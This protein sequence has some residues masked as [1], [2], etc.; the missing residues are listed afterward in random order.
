M[1][2][3]RAALQ[4]DYTGLRVRLE[5]LNDPES[6]FELGEDAR[7]AALASLADEYL[8]PL[9]DSYERLERVC[10]PRVVSNQEKKPQ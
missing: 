5:Q 1:S 6:R 10:Y 9:L 4:P 7:R 8:L 2:G 3:R